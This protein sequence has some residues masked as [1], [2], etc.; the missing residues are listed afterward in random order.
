MAWDLGRDLD[1]AFT[2]GLDAVTVEYGAEVAGGFRNLEDME[3]PDG[4]GVGRVVQAGEVCWIQAGQM[5][6]LEAALA[7]DG[8]PTITLDGASYRVR[9]PRRQAA[10]AYLQLILVPS[11]PPVED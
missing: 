9:S 11:N 8:E 5:P 10:G 1:H 2:D 6:Q 4:T 7:A 3:V